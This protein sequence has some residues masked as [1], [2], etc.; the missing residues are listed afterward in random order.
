[1]AKREYYDL[2]LE[3]M[4]RSER[5]KYFNEKLRWIVNYAYR[6]A[7]AVREKFDRAGVKPSQI[8]SVKDLELVPITRKDE[9]IKLQQ[10]RPVFGGF[11]TTS[12]E[13]LRRI[14]ISPGPIYD[15]QGDVDDYWQGAK[16]LYAA[17]LRK[18]DV[19]LNTFAYH[20]TPAGCMMDEAARKLGCTVIPS[21]VGNTDLQ[22]QLLYQLKV[23]AFI[24]TPSFL[25]TII[26]RAEELGYDFHRFSL[27]HAFLGAEMVPPS[28]KKIFEEDYGIRV[29]EGYGSADVGMIAYE[30]DQ[31][32][33]L[34][35]CDHL[36]IEIVDPTTNKTLGPGEVGEVVVTLFNKIYPLIRFGIGDASLYT[37]EPCPCGRTSDRLVRIVGRVGDAVKVRGMFL[38]PRQ[39]EEALSKF[40]QVSRFQTVVSRVGH[41][42]VFTYRIELSDETVNQKELAEA[43][44]KESLSIV[45][46]K[47]DKIEFVPQGTIPE[48]A[49][50][51]VDARTWE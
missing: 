20:L 41:R 18:G 11:L 9:L 4:P 32:S 47:A 26:K 15:P 29:T 48:G 1:M 5:E 30:C 2:S 33:G 50:K 19:V 8:R 39:V 16:V 45:K 28:M 7:P 36:I 46:L 49:K 37:A 17:G 14:F 21:G 24:G 35:I 25:M 23:T 13:K 6:K 42:D 40:P 43:I 3:T 38:H 12:P 31:K 34:H 51:L 22:V 44:Q 10:E 27:R